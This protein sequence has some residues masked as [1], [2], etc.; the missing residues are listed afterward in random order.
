MRTNGPRYP[1]LYEI[2][3]QVYLSELA[4]ELGRPA[5]LD[6][7]PDR[8]LDAWSDAGFDLIW[9][10]GMW[11]TGAAGRTVAA[12]EPE[13]LAEYRRAL[14]DFELADVCGSCFAVQDYRPHEDFG[15]EEALNRLRRRMS[16]RGLR[17]ILDFVPN[18]TALDHRWVVEHPE[19]YVQGTE[20]QLAAQP[21]NYVR[22]DCPGGPRIL[23]HGRD[24]HF[25]GW[26]DTLQLN[27]GDPG[28]QRAMI[29]EL[30]RVASCCDGVRCDMAMLLL[31]EV[32]ERTR[33]IAIEP[34]WPGAIDTI[35]REAPKFLFLAEVYWDLEWTLQRQGFD[36]TYDKRLYDRLRRGD[37]G[38]VR[39]HM[40]AG[41]DFQDRLIRFLENHDEDRAAAAFRPE[42]HRAAATI[43][44]LAPGLRFFHYGQL[45][46]RKTRVPVQ[47]RRGPAE[48]ADTDLSH[49]YAALL[50]VLWDPVLR[51]GDW[52][53]L[54]CQ[55]AWDGN[56]TWDCFLAFSWSGRE[57][58]RYLVA[59]NCA[60]HPSQCY[61]RIP[62]PDLDGS[63]WR[64]RDQLGPAVYDREGRDLAA[65][66]LYLDVE[67]WTCH[68]F[69]ALP[70]LG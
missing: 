11:Q 37:A 47:L 2:N 40:R 55:P 57:G 15:G 1:S 69:E 32:F 35:R 28:L 48:P 14:P 8:D 34:F 3:A 59:V 18:H 19:Y 5:S 12:S 30:R 44:F 6:D 25:G 41:L 17:L 45:E 39:S 43:T 22:L 60:D 42:V 58:R 31:P 7:V 56:W 13:M 53:L 27:Y 21:R 46:G 67:P 23:A 20:A 50:G 65:R 64:F 52:R 63:E 38:S 16:D 29:G 51:E 61:V 33:G 26:T 49:F 66:G 70:A 68:I 9:F 54:E 4:R 36:Y 24:P 10:L 62:W